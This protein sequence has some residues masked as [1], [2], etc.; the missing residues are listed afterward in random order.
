MNNTQIIN[1]WQVRV[2]AAEAKI[3]E[4]R[5][6]KDHDQNSWVLECLRAEIYR[7]CIADLK[8]AV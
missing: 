2:D 8:K 3:K 5:E 6:T 7:V 4:M 1:E